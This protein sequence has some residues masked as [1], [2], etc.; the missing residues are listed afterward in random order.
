MIKF[1]YFNKITKLH[2]DNIQ[3]QN[4]IYKLYY[5]PEWSQTLGIIILFLS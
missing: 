1:L 3:L 5:W 4:Q 2:N